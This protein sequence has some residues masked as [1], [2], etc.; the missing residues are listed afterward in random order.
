[1][2]T[3]PYDF[4]RP[5]K[6]R[7]FFAGRKS[8]LEEVKY[9][10]EQ[11]S[12][13]SPKFLSLALI[14]RRASGKTSLLNMIGL[15]AEDM[16]FLP[17]KLSLNNELVTS[18]VA[19]FKEVFDG[20][21]TRGSEVGMY[22]GLGQKT[23]KHFR[24]LIDTLDLRVELPLLFGTAYVGSK[25]SPEVRLPQHIVIHDLNEMYEEA[26]KKG[27][28]G[29]V[30]L[31]DECDLLST[32][33]TLLQKMRNI[34]QDIDGY[35]LVLAGTETMFPKL[36][37]VFSPIPR[38]FKRIDVKDFQSRDE[39][40][41]CILMPLSK[42]ERKSFHEETARDIHTL[43]RGSPYEINLVSHFMYKRYMDG[44]DNMMKLT[45]DV[46]DDVMSEIERL[47]Q[48]GH[49]DVAS[50]AKRFS[51]EEL[52]MLQYLSD[53]EPIDR[54]AYISFTLLFDIEELSATN[55]DD[56][57]EKNTAVLDRL[58]HLGTVRQSESGVL[59]LVGDDFDELYIKYLASSKGVVALPF[60]GT[61]DMI[62]KYLSELMLK[63]CACS[64]SMQV[65][66]QTD[67][68][69]WDSEYPP[70]S[71]PHKPWRID[72]LAKLLAPRTE[73][74][75][76]IGVTLRCQQTGY[77]ADLL[78]MYESQLKNEDVRATM[79]LFSE[80]M[81]LAG[82]QAVWPSITEL[83]LKGTHAYERG[84]YQEALGWFREAERTGLGSFIADY[85][86]AVTLHKLGDFHGAVDS[87]SKMLERVSKVRRPEMS[88][89]WVLASVCQRDDGNL[90]EALRLI[91]KAIAL[92][93]KSVDSWK[94]KAKVLDLKGQ[95]EDAAECLKTAKALEESE[96]KKPGELLRKRR[97]RP[98]AD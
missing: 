86:L 57:R 77:L 96:T 37:Q 9:Y 27:I 15:M 50:R 41:E 92:D 51:L 81:A 18:D 11:A 22:G 88:T 2:P 48:G 66:L 55:Q 34:F 13:E 85:D 21:M 3:N 60:G 84:D 95:G 5:I 61:V 89:I 59:S 7:R 23:Y 80:K 30:L 14:G 71:L 8:E 32:N 29:I 52:K 10:F 68:S 12:G 35:I 49:H 69:F 28:R 24:K 33:E 64:F 74:S 83:L 6:D 78:Y 46:L 45:V 93:P 17:V 4:T 19:F 47:R 43:T 40:L 38:F 72:N 79:T 16:G 91:N 67:M 97:T 1:M 65:L 82:L 98:T 76:V 94:E 25:S 90:E 44:K 39:T 62:D 73:S 20:I 36:S 54:S 42:K 75:E 58:I 31:L 63:R 87:C 53:L 56:Y 26:K 70:L